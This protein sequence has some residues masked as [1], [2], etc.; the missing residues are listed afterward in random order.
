MSK[1]ETL[2]IIKDCIDKRKSFILEAGAGSGKTWSLV[3]SLKYILETKGKYL[4]KQNKKIAC[5]TYTN[6]A[7]DEI[8]HRIDNNPLVYVG[9]IHSFLWS[10]VSEY[11]EELKNIMLE[12]NETL[13]V[14]KKNDNLKEDLAKVRKLEYNLYKK[15]YS[16]GLLWHNDV[17]DLSCKLF[18]RYK[19][20]IQ[21]TI[22]KYPYLFIDEYQDTFPVIINLILDTI[23]SK[24]KDKIV[25]GFY[26]DSMQNIYD[27]GIGNLKLE[28]YSEIEQITKLEN[29][30]CSTTVIDLLK[31]IR[32]D[33]EQYPA[34]SNKKGEISFYHGEQGLSLDT[35]KATLE[36]RKWNFT[37]TTN[38]KIL[39]LTHKKI[40]EG[41]GY[42]NLLAAFPHRDSLFDRGNFL[43]NIFFQIEDICRN[44][45]EG[46][47]GTL[48]SR[49]KSNG[50]VLSKHQEKQRL[51]EYIDEL[52]VYRENKKIT[53]VLD[54]IAT[55][56]IQLIQTQDYLLF[57]KKIEQDKTDDE[58]DERNITIYKKLKAISFKEVIAL[59]SFIEDHTVYSTKHGVK[60]S[61]FENV[62]LIVD[63]RAW[64]NFNDN[65][66]FGDDKL[67]NPE[68][69]NRTRNLLYVCCSRAKN[70]LALYSTTPMS[71]SSKRTIEKWFG[72]EN[73]FF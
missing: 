53:E 24:F 42:S 13:S 55:H 61:E 8:M 67:S 15:D 19:K 58:D 29:Y 37:D 36:K 69:Y 2:D 35:V 26:G 31:H 11:S 68:R 59:Y 4:E 6:V 21:I 16:K 33:L 54:F 72:V 1:K 39:Y 49:L 22:S 28:N 65:Q 43:A 25:I 18:E 51:R 47:Y 40:A 62:L 12:I 48:F 20:L 17:V 7:A 3:E 73:V 70:K 23:Y 56:D 52:N 34:G 64:N 30:R 63:D 46:N 32:P 50:F 14:D 66:V 27:T 10:Q 57:I 5:I 60:G 38:T 9:T 41:I 44:Y 45:Q 71:L